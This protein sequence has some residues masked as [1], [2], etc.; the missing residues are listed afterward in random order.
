[1][2]QELAG[3]LYEA[4]DNGHRV[5]PVKVEKILGVPK[6]TQCNGTS[7]ISCKFISSLFCTFLFVLS[8]VSEFSSASP[9]HCDAS[10]LI[11]KCIPMV[12]L[13]LTLGVVTSLI[14]HLLS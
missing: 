12:T 13:P 14:G 11:S 10:K 1:M 2:F 4:V 8:F 5:D 3:R 9:I 7:E 6:S